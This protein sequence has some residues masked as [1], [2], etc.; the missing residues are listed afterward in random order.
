LDNVCPIN[1]AVD[2]HGPGG[3][4]GSMGSEVVGEV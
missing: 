2:R 1:D 3:G 4:I